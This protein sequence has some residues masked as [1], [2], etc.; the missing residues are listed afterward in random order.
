[1]P[2]RFHP[3]AAT[4]ALEARGWYEARSPLSALGFAQEID[5]AV[6][7]IAEAPARHPIA[8]S[9]TRRLRLRRY[10]F[11]LFYRQVGP[12]FEIVAVAHDKRRPGYWAR[13]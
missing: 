2:V 1:M 13:R 9:G 12:V 8:E 11:S 3:A 6:H 4:E 7:L 10:P 5:Q